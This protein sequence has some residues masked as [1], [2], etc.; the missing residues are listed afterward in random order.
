MISL[1]RFELLKIRRSKRVLATA[2]V[3]LLYLGLMLLGFYTYAQNE[4]GGR[5][6][7]RYTYENS[8]YFNGLT[9]G[10]YAFYFGALM[11][12]PIFS[13]AEGASQIA[14][15][16]YRRTLQLLLF[17]QVSRSRIFLGK[18]LLAFIYQT[19]LVGLLMVLALT[20]GLLLVGWGDLNIYPGVLQMTD[21]H[22]RLSQAE[23]LRAFFFAWLA[24]SLGMLVPLALSFL[25]ATWMR[26]PI[27]VVASSIAVYLVLLVISEVH[28]FADLR[29]Y[30]FT[31]YMGFWR[32]FFRERI[33]WPVLLGDCAR[34]LAFG[35]GFIAVAH[36]RFRTREE[37]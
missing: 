19:A 31:S 37:T 1:L 8:G 23:A 32:E 16:S 27:N 24:A 36:W 10:L 12:L 7:F 6:E 3:L 35:F 30:L 26:S 11:V 17:R 21:A 20:L 33:D 15:E 2:T 34:L 18:L 14:G 28:F 25:L 5:A 13:A 22:Q 9:F 29:P 4:T